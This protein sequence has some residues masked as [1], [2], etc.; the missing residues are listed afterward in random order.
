[1]HRVGFAIAGIFLLKAEFNGSGI[2]K[3]AGDTSERG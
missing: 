2:L 1:M 3:R